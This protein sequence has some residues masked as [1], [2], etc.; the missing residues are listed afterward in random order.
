MDFRRRLARLL[1]RPGI[2]SDALSPRFEF[3]G[4]FGFVPVGATNVM[5]MGEVILREDE[6]PAALAEAHRQ[7]RRA[8]K[9]RDATHQAY[10][11]AIDGRL[12]SD[13]RYSRKA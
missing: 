6:T 9:D 4:Y 11:R 5:A 3:T 7:A 8:G 2:G 10:R 13:R 12:V 1:G